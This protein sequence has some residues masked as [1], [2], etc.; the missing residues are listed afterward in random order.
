MCKKKETYD[1]DHDN[2]DITTLGD[3]DILAKT[4]FLVTDLMTI[5]S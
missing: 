4:F 3:T 5:Y 1:I 2:R